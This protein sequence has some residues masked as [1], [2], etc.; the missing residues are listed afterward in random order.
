MPGFPIL[1]TGFLENHKFP[2]FIF[3]LAFCKVCSMLW[4]LL[5]PNNLQLDLCFPVLCV[6]VYT[7]MCT[8]VCRQS[9]AAS[10]MCFRQGFPLESKALIQ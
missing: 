1:S 8:Q 10:T 6:C 7:L 2:L 3:A 5:V 9:H 4:Q